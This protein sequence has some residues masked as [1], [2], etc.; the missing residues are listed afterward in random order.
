MPVVK[1][2]NNDPK[3]AL[4]KSKI[5]N[6]GKVNAL[7]LSLV[8]PK[9][10][11]AKR[12]NYIQQTVFTFALALDF[13]MKPFF[14]KEMI[15][16][17]VTFLFSCKVKKLKDKRLENHVSQFLS[18]NSVSTHKSEKKRVGTDKS[19]YCRTE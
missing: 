14:M 10:E 2:H 1:N 13:S 15:Y 5:L 8:K 16:E 19:L 11:W 4:V 12:T 6:S 3:I 7:P 18:E 9:A 17:E